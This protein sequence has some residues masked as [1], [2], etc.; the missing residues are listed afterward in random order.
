MLNKL[1]NVLT[2]K[3]TLPENDIIKIVSHERVNGLDIFYGICKKKITQNDI[4]PLTQIM[5]AMYHTDVYITID[6]SDPHKIKVVSKKKEHSED[7]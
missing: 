1:R 3:S 4:K 5:E 7:Q 6:T 2:Q